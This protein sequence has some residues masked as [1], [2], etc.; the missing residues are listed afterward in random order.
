M[1]SA[2]DISMTP[3]D[4][5]THDAEDA[6]APRRGR[7]D[8]TCAEVVTTVRFWIEQRRLVAGDR[9]PSER[10]L[11]RRLGVA[12][13][14][15]RSALDRLQSEGL[16]RQD[17]RHRIVRETG[18]KPGVV[19]QSIVVIGDAPRAPADGRQTTGWEDFIETGAFDA[20]RERGLHA[21]AVNTNRLVTDG[22]GILVRERPLGCLVSRIA[23]ES[24]IGMELMSALSFS[25]LRVVAYGDHPGLAPYDRV[26]SDHA[27]GARALTEWLLAR[28]RK[29]ILRVWPA[30]AT[31]P[32][33]LRQR[34]AGHE[35]AMEE[36]GLDTIPPLRF[37][38]R[39]IGDDRG[40]FEQD[41]RLMAGYMVEHFRSAR[42]IDAVMV[43]SDRTI[44]NVAAVCRIMGK[45]AGRDVLVVGYD[46]YWQDCVERAWEP[47]APSA[48]VDKMN[49]KMGTEMVDLLMQRVEGRLSDEPQLRL[50]EPK[51][52]VCEGRQP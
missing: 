42:P 52:V 36:A 13:G 33:W 48:T 34:D 50:I 2:G 25:G 11:S 51:L 29:R 47:F 41:C 16:I 40:L 17:G 14:T 49:A 43:V 15:L 28:G 12:R 27:W 22:A 38:F 30:C 37:P 10:V 26:A 21:L 46:N 1:E 7:P 20:I 3:A 5:D 4:A 18:P 8:D 9:L 24:V 44:Y 45:E 35:R 23:G 39:E 31:D 6:P 32:A 19:S